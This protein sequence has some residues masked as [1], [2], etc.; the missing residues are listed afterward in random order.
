MKSKTQS[1]SLEADS[2]SPSR[3]IL[4]ILCNEKFRY[5]RYDKNKIK[6]CI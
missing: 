3:K 2:Y 5:R 4:R 1:S 6:K